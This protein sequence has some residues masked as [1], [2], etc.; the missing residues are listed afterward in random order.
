MSDPNSTPSDSTP[1]HAKGPGATTPD[2]TPVEPRPDA[3]GAPQA[4]P[5]A[6]EPSPSSPEPTEPATPE[7]PAGAREPET[8]V[9]ESTEATAAPA[10]TGAAPTERTQTVPGSSNDRDDATNAYPYERA[11]ATNPSSDHTVTEAY[12]DSA[13]TERVLTGPEPTRAYEPRQTPPPNDGT[14]GGAPEHVEVA[15]EPKR[16]GNRWAGIG[17]GVIQALVFAA[18]MFGVLILIDLISGEQPDLLGTLLSPAL[19][20]ATGMFF[21]G[22]VIVSLLVNRAGWWAWIL[23]G[24]L[25]AAFA[26]VGWIGGLLVQD[27]MSVPSNR[28]LEFI[29]ENLLTWPSVAAFILGREIPIWFGAWTAAR[30]RKV[31]ARNREARD[32][33]ERRLD[34]RDA[35]YR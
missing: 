33:Y 25:I 14:W 9:F 34:E 19:L 16:K 18:A 15:E 6:P 1:E 7:R 27:A 10:D 30:G 26:Y 11:P 5:A 17:I 21:I 22:L 32:D 29:W 12:T 23:G 4:P 2:P 13:S 31:A 3:P 8:P 24:L 35:A 28:V 20:I